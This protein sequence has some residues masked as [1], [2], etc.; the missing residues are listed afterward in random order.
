MPSKG[1]SPT[2]R[3]LERL[4]AEGFIAEVVEKVIPGCFIKRDFI[5]CI[6]II[7]FRPESPVH[8]YAEAWYPREIVGIQA[9]SGSNHAARRTKALDI[10]ELKLW[11]Q[12]GGQFEVWS[13]S[14]PKEGR[15]WALRRER[16]T[17]GHFHERINH[18][19]NQDKETV[20][21]DS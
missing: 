10:P 4:R 3:S 5:H 13:W 9:T 12:A 14:P 16:I 21:S 1:K 8:P 18:D 11:L 7:A 6:D 20:K 15:K 2:A 17:L 19:N